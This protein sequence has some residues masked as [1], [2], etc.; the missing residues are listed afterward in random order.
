MDYAELH[1]N[2]INAIRYGNPEVQ[3]EWMGTVIDYE[4]C[5]RLKINYTSP[6][7]PR[8]LRDFESVFVQSLDYSKGPN[9]GDLV[10]LLSIAMQSHDSAVKNAATDLVQRCAHTWA[11]M[12]EDIIED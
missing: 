9:H 7:A 2:F 8:K 3:S 12:N 10:V 6:G 1:D 11:T 4:K 5:N